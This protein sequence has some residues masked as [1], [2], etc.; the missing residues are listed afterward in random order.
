MG[1]LDGKV[2]VITGGAS[3]IGKA[4][5]RLFVNEGARVVFGDVL[6]DQAEMLVKELGPSAV[7]QHTDVAREEEIESLIS[8]A[9]KRF[10]RLDCLFNNAA[11]GGAG[12]MIEEIPTLGFDVTIAVNFRSV[13]FGMKYAA[14]VMKKQRSGTIISTASVAGQRTGYGG[15]LYSACKA[16]IIQMTRTVALELGPFGIRVNSICPGGVVTSIFGRNLGLD[17]EASEGTYPGLSEVFRDLQAIPRP[18]MPEDIAKV[19]LWLA[20]EDS[21]YVNGAAINVDGGLPDG[22]SARLDIVEKVGRILGVEIPMPE[23]PPLDN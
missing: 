23:K 15:H 17:Q 20:H 6:D 13:Y 11:I 19:A 16:A 4:T 10:G 3:G 12:G 1:K 14:P 2:A 7:F 5:V 8:L 18:C 21:G 22:L 9:V